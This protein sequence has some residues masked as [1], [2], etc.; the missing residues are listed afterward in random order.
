MNTNCWEVS[1][2]P[3]LQPA[4]SVG[5]SSPDMLFERIKYLQKQF[6]HEV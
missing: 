1:N 2:F 4:K 3:L 6:I 5:C